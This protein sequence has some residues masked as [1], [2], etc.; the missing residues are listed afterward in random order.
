MNLNS[1]P[2]TDEVPQQLRKRQLAAR[3]YDRDGMMLGAELT[4]GTKLEGAI[5]RLF[6][7]PRTAYLHLHYPAPGC[8]AARVERA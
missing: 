6:S 8:Y 4:E 7:E 2:P 5:E 1:S 3:A